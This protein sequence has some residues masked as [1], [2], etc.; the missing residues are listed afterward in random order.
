M[1]QSLH[2]R[3][4]DFKEEH[5]LIQC[6]CWNVNFYDFVVK[7]EKIVILSLSGSYFSKILLTTRLVI[8]KRRF[9]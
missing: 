4:G 6:V 3:K 5:V 9:I 8:Y 7:V 2:Y 1:K